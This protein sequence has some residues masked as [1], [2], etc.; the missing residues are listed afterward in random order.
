MV[1]LGQKPYNFCGATQIGVFENA[2]SAACKHTPFLDNGGKTRRTY[3][4]ED[5]AAA[6]FSP[7]SAVHSAGL[8]L[9]PF[10]RRRLAERNASCLLVCFIGLT[11]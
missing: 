4:R 6:S 7:P 9:P 11:L 1:P 10:H 3:W 8:L 2:L 5:L